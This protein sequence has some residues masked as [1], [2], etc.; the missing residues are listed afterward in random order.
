M[1]RAL[2]PN[3]GFDPVKDLA[4]VSLTSWGQLVLV[5]S[6]KSGIKSAG[7]LVAKAKAQP[8]ALNYGS[9]GAGT[10]HHL[11][12]ELVKNEAGVSLTHVPY[13]GTGPALTDLLAGTIDA[14]F[15]PI[16]V[17]LQHVKAGSLRALAISSEKPHPLLP[18]VPPLRSLGM[19]DLDVEMWYGVM[20]PANTPQAAGRPAERRAEGDP[21]A[22][23]GQGRVPDPGHGPGAQLTGRVPGAG[24]QGCRPLG[25]A[26]PGPED[27]RELRPVRQDQSTLTFARLITAAYLTASRS[28]IC[29]N[30]CGE[31]GAGV[32][33]S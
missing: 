32:A 33:A 7:E 17:A 23:R 11:A 19:G 15:L 16:H 27:H 6:P 14:M 24:A 29:A 5:A 4:P 18:E 22:A 13:R 26:D 1:N 8:G 30:A 9:P 21:G 12:M 3:A 20:A 25:K 2:Y 10:P 31:F 28:M